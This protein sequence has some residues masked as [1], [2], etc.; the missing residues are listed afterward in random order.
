[1]E[2]LFVLICDKK[3]SVVYFYPTASYI[4]PTPS[5]MSSSYHTLASS[6]TM[7]TPLDFH[8]HV[9]A[10]CAQICRNTLGSYSCSC[11]SGYHLA[12]DGKSC[13]GKAPSKTIT[14]LECFGIFLF[15]R[16]SALIFCAYPHCVRN[17][18]RNVKPHHAYRAG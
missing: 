12:S 14:A 4:A 11:V 1:M 9:P 6:S 7:P 17:S 2:V 16:I 10:D 15:L 13:L 3:L 5:S 18:C 8:L